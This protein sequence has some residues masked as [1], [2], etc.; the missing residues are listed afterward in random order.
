MPT[1]INGWNSQ[2]MSNFVHLIFRQLP[3]GTSSQV[4]KEYDS[5]TPTRKLTLFHPNVIGNC[6]LDQLIQ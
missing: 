3:W 6:K 1:E 5:S 4:M 2:L